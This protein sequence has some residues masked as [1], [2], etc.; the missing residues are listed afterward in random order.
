[1][2]MAPKNCAQYLDTFDTR[3]KFVARIIWMDHAHMVL[4]ALLFMILT[5]SNKN[6]GIKLQKH[7]LQQPWLYLVININHPPPIN[8]DTMS[9]VAMVISIIEEIAVDLKTMVYQLVAEVVAVAV[10][11]K[12]A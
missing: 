1:M 11:M 12:V 6:S 7:L 9:L 3:R 4:D 8:R 2:L 10:L 5:F